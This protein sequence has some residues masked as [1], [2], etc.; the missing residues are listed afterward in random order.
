MMDVK[1]ELINQSYNKTA[2]Y[3]PETNRPKTDSS[4]LSGGFYPFGG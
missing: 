2:N 1:S 4:S 3:E